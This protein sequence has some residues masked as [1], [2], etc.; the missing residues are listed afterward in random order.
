MIIPYIGLT[1]I[2]ANEG[3]A[4]ND[5]FSVAFVRKKMYV[6][7]YTSTCV[8]IPEGYVGLLCARSSISNYDLMLANGIGVIDSGY[9]G[10]IKVR[11]KI[12]P[13]WRNLFGLFPKIY[14]LEDKIAQLVIVPFQSIEWEKTDRL[15]SSE[16]GGGGFGSSGK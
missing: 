6:E 3:D 10:E 1:P 7:Y 2:V 8:A 12:I 5:L 13:T 16:R 15:Q 4:G 9:R 11:F 14:S